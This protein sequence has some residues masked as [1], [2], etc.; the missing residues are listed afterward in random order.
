MKDKVASLDDILKVIDKDE[1]IRLSENL[2]LDKGVIDKISKLM[3]PLKR[4]N[5]D[6]KIQCISML[7]FD[8]TLKPLERAMTSIKKFNRM[9]ESEVITPYNVCDEMVALLPEEGLREI[10][11][12]QEKFLDIAAKSGEYA[13]SLYKRLTDGLGYS[14]EDVKDTI[15][16]I[17]TSSIAYEFTRKFYEILDLNV[18]NIAVNF[19]AYDLL[20]VKNDKNEVDYDKISSL[21]R[22]GKK[23]S[24]ITLKEEIKAGEETVNFG[25]VIG[26]PP[27]QLSDGGA[28]ASAK[29]I[30]QHFVLLGKKLSSKYSCY[31]TPTRWF[32]GGKGLDNF[33]D[34]MLRDETI[35]ELHD[36]LTPEDVFP[37]TNNRGGVCYFLNDIS[38]IDKNVKF[39]T[40]KNNR[41]ISEI[42]R[43]LLINGID[44]FLRDNMG[45]DI[46]NK[47]NDYGCKSFLEEIISARKPFG[48]DGNFVSNEKF[49]NNKN[50]IKNPLKCY[51]KSQKIGFIDSDII[52]KNKQWIKS[53][54]VFTPYANNIGT[55]LNDDN[56]NSFVGEPNSVCTETFLTIGAELN[57]SKKAAKSLS[58]Y[59]RTKFARYLHS[60]AKISQHGTKQTYR[61]VPMQDFTDNSDVDW[62]KSIA[63]IDEQ[64]FDKYHLSS[65]EREHIKNSIK[66]M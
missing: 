35:K 40:H 14:H 47:L 36:F 13:V 59:L 60:L 29:P 55:E 42:D 62:T 53:W 39:V 1:N 44:I 5:L 27:Y 64:L 50:G 15:Y 18:E 11:L 6:Y 17:P 49:K 26:N 45:I 9:S 8:K 48:L 33:R 21:L 16:S 58:V 51:G 3:D 32:A 46:I 24:E 43:P 19:N 57:L 56:Q 52:E 20:D 37:N 61:F 31:I 54:K 34:M 28:Q 66:D 25:A 63:D 65:E 12:N 30:Y 2:F 22:Q 7:A 4:S 38:K 23:F 41:K 10:V